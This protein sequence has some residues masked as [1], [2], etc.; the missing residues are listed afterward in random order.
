MEE[1]QTRRHDASASLIPDIDTALTRR[2][3][4]RMLL[5]TG[6]FAGAA[7]GQAMLPRSVFAVDR[8]DLDNAQDALDDA[9]EEY[10]KVKAQL[11]K[12]GAEY[13]ELAKE[14]AATLNQIETVQGQIDD[15]QEQIDQTQ[16]DIEQK[17][18]DLDAKKDT[19]AK[20][21]STA[22]KAGGSNFLDVLL[23]STS[24]EE[25]SSNIYYLD[26]ISEADADMIAEVKK[27]KEELDQQKAVQE[28]QKA[29]LEEQQDQ[30]E[31]LNETQKQQLA[32]MDAKK[33]EVNETLSGLSAEV[34]QLMAERDQE[35]VEYNNARL[36]E[37]KAAAAE[38]ARR[39][40][41]ENNN[42]GGN[43]GGNN[44]GGGSEQRNATTGSQAAIVAACKSTPSPGGGLCAMW[45]SLVFYKA[46]YGYYGGDAC[47]MYSSWCTSSNRNDL[48]VGMIVAVSTHSHTAA[49]RIYGHI[50]IYIGGGM[51]MDNIGYIRT[52]SVDSWISF[53]STTVTPRWG[54]LGGRVLS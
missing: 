37:Q 16:A 5:A 15:A 40:A 49:G 19:L 46:G 17:Q 23:S 27:A 13:Q 50:G 29:A 54:W 4:L 32:D 34:S 10:N 14:Q 9:Q 39:K 51:I 6:A 42:S 31:Q 3:A 21:V 18:K 53:Y 45:V 1:K 2:A 30:L 28:Q 33:D 12:I 7:A 20:R 38:A 11:D 8:T 35:H 41:Q 24:F 25:L 48:K 26:K 52:S 22:Y 44:S 43:N 36:E 47:D